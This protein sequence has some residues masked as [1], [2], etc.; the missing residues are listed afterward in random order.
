MKS[1]RIIH[2]FFL[3]IVQISSLKGDEPSDILDQCSATLNIS[4]E[5]CSIERFNGGVSNR[6]YLISTKSG[7]KLAAKVFTR[8]SLGDVY[9][10]EHTLSA[11]RDMGFQIPE[12]VAITLFQDKFPLHISRF[13]EGA[14]LIDQDLF[15][16]ARLMAELHI[17]GSSINPSPIKKYRGEEHYRNL[18]KKCENWAYTGEL[19]KIYEELDLS[20]LS[21]IPTGT[22]HGDFSYTNLIH[23]ENGK[24]TLLDF[25]NVCTSYLL[26]DLVRCHMFYGFDKEGELQE[27]KVN[28]FV[29]N[30]NAIRPLTLAERQN[31]YSHMKLMMIDTALG[32]WYN[33]HIARDLP[34]DV[35]NC[36]ENKTLVPE[37]LF[38][39]IKSLQGKKDIN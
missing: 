17:K 28:N 34:I 5:S 14:H 13:Q 8:Y 24:L 33:I 27:E 19:K 26:T 7:E 10:I 32:I 36:L 3:L 29:S 35:V 6:V 23:T 12:T 25:D 31:F 38:K 4:L 11:L 21:E 22:I 16:V 1:K 37:L 39:K 15:L 2:I 18:F 9:K 20:Y 30:Y